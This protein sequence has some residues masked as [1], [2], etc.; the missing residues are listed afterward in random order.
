MQVVFFSFQ[1]VDSLN[2]LNCIDSFALYSSECV[3][4]QTLTTQDRKV[5]YIKQGKTQ[6]DS[7]LGPGWYRFQGAAG[8][9]MPIKCP[10]HY[11]R[12]TNGPGWLKGGHPTVAE[13]KVTR[14]VCFNWHNC[15]NINVDI[16]VRNC[17]SFYVY[18]LKATSSCY[19]RYCS[20][21]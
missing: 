10:P 17:G 21:D 15:C 11:R 4:Y 7:T 12:N 13:G 18:Y 16:K 9:K 8:T 14:Q 19:Y 1:F 3:N 6:C 20:T 5:T 2:A